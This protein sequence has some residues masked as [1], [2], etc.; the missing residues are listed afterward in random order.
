MSKNNHILPFG[1]PKIKT[2]FIFINEPS[3]IR[4]YVEISLRDIKKHFMQGQDILKGINYSFLHNHTYAITGAS[5]SGKSTL[6]HI[7]AGLDKPSSGSITTN[8]SFG[9]VFQTPYL[10]KE[11]SVLQNIMIKGLI[12]NDN[13]ST[14]KERAHMLL[15]RIN[16]EDKA[17]SHP[18]SLSG[19]Q[20]QKIAILRAIYNKPDFLLADEPTGNLDEESGEVILDL[21]LEYQK[22]WSMGLTI[23][24]HDRNVTKRMQTMLKLINGVL[25]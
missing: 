12:N 3:I 10:I 9:V 21:L 14:C 6:L 16:L 25:N 5:G 22:Q 7:I 1:L 15:K 18:N 8:K 2:G 11:L 19:G 23:C 24:S 17:D 20:Q 4:T 13:V